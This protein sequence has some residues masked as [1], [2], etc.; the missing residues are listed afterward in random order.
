MGTYAVK[1]QKNVNRSVANYSFRGQ[2]GSKS[3]FRFADNRP[4]AISQR[5]LQEMVDN[6]SQVRQLRKNKHVELAA[7]KH[8]NDGWGAKYGIQTDDTL[9]EKVSDGVKGEGEVSLGIYEFGK[10]WFFKGDQYKKG[11]E[12][13]IQYND[14]EE[15]WGKHKTKFTSIYHCGPSGE[16]R[17]KK[18]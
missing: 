3:I 8:Y 7:R 2:R 9:K 5:K 15:G 4:E 17:I 16:S 12:C 6:S 18:V 11:K 14:G 1:R 10:R 13:T